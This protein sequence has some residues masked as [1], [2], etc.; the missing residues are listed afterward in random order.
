MSTATE[1]SD[2]EEIVRAAAERRPIDPEVSK[3]VRERA[4]RIREELRQKYGTLD[5]A[6]DLIREF[7]DQ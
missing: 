1:Q 6:I 2:H 4:E 7:R 5:V 3:R